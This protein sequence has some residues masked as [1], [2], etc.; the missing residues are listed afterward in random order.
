VLKFDRER[1]VDAAAFPG[2]VS[3]AS[4]V[5]ISPGQVTEGADATFTFSSSLAL[6]QPVTIHYVMG[7]QAQ[8]GLDYTLSGTPGQVTM[9]AGRSSTTETLHAI[10]DH[11]KERKE[12]VVVSLTNDTNYNAPKRAKATLTIVNGP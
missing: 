1:G 2:A 11:V 8:L 3:G 6:S 4:N 10:A 5:S 9:N 7:G 12:T